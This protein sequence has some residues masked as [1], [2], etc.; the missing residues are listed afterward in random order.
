MKGYVVDCTGFSEEKKKLVQEGFFRL[1]IKWFY[2]NNSI[3]FLYRD[4][5]TN[6]E[7]GGRVTDILTWGCRITEDMKP[8]L[9]S[10]NDF[11]KEVGMEEHMEKE[12]IDEN[13]VV[14]VEMTVGQ[15]LILALLSGHSVDSSNYN[16]YEV[17]Y[18]KCKELGLTDTL[19]GLLD[20]GCVTGGEISRLTREFIRDHL[21][22]KETPNQ[23][24]ARE[25]RERAE[26]FLA[27]AKE[28]EESV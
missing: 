15:L 28:L 21:K 23:K 2:S 5:F 14:S 10:F 24:K 9:I 1:G 13:T 6:V 16:Q 3:S 7:I 11:M 26:E 8:Y 25:L 12:A 17:L 18:N 19:Y 22:P 27:K 20:R 4:V